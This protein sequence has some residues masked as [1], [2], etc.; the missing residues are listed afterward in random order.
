MLAGRQS[1]SDPTEIRFPIGAV[2][3]RTAAGAGVDRRLPC[4]FSLTHACACLPGEPDGKRHASV[5]GC[6]LPAS[7]PARSL[8]HPVLWAC[9][10][11]CLLL[12]DRLLHPV[13][14]A[15]TL[16]GH[17]PDKLLVPCTCR[18]VG[19]GRCLPAAVT[20]NSQI[21]CAQVVKTHCQVPRQCSR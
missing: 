10:S 3:W 12:L 4:L 6:C 1:A 7:P 11:S 5:C 20:T 2:K 14:W 18:Q 9:F 19:T 16:N 21:F 8:L 15:L 17:A 13:L